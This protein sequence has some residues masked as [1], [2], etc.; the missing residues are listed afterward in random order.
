MKSLFLLSSLF[1]SLSATSAFAVVRPKISHTSGSNG[2]QSTN[3]SLKI[4]TDFYLEPSYRAFSSDSASETFKT[5]ALRAGF[6]GPQW[7]IGF[8]GGVQPEA[9]LYK[10]EFL[11]VDSWFEFPLSG[12]S[13]KN[14][15]DQ[16]LMTLGAG[17]MGT[18]HTDK[19][20]NAVLAGIVEDNGLSQSVRSLRRGRGGDDPTAPRVAAAEIYQTELSV[21]AG[22]EFF[23][24]VSLDATM[25][26]SSYDKD[27]TAISA[28]N[29][30]DDDF[31][32]ALAVSSGYR[33][34]SLSTRLTFLSLPYIIPYV[35]YSRISF[36]LDDPTATTVGVGA[37]VSLKPIAISV[38]Y[39]SYDPGGAQSKS[40]YTTIGGGVRF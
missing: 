18:R 31:D 20:Q 16:I 36:E 2:Y 23:S 3:I 29:I 28:R 19:L 6:D 8:E 9:N 33:D 15:Q 34:S 10:N 5:Y 4:G 1:L 35:S 26:K 22:L 11:G 38:S 14:E 13:S 30:L 27:L 24:Q 37:S 25:A 17:V 40:H 7:G 39:E 21:S 12:T 32:G